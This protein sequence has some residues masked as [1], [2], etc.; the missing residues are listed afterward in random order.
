MIK[1]WY[2]RYASKHLPDKVVHVGSVV[3]LRRWHLIPKNRF[4]NIYLHNFLGDDKRVMHDHPWASLSYMLRGF[5]LETYQKGGATSPRRNR[6]V[7]AGS[8]KYRDS[9][10]LHYLQPS[11]MNPPWTIFITGPKTKRWGFLSKFGMVPKSVFSKR[12]TYR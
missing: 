12:Q 9:K 4:F 1:P 5:F 3:Y 11:K 8:W 7:S 10:F 2:L 6:I